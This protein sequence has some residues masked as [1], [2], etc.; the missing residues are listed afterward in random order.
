M[1]ENT[2]APVVD[3]SY[4]FSNP[5][6]GPAPEG[7]YMR[8]GKGTI[9]DTDITLDNRFLIVATNLGLYVY[10]VNSLKLTR[11]LPVEVE[12]YQ[13]EINP[14]GTSFVSTDF[15]GNLTNW[16][17]PTFELRETILIA[18]QG[19]KDIEFTSD[20][21]R[22]IIA[23]LDQ[24]IRNLDT[25]KGGIIKTIFFESV[26]P[27]SLD[28]H[29][30]DK[31]IAVLFGNSSFS[32]YDIES[33]IAVASI[34][35]PNNKNQDLPSDDVYYYNWFNDRIYYSV[36]GSLLYISTRSHRDV[37]RTI[38]YEKI[39]TFSKTMDFAESTDLIKVATIKEDSLIITELDTGHAKV[40]PPIYGGSSLNNGGTY[41]EIYF[42]HDSTRLIQVE[43]Y[44]I[45]LYDLEDDY[46]VHTL[47][48]YE[49]FEYIDYLNNTNQLLTRSMNNPFGLNP[50][51][52]WDENLET[53][54]NLED[55]I[56][57]KN[58]V[59]HGEEPQFFIQ[60]PDGNFIAGTLDEPYPE[61]SR[62][63]YLWN[64][65][66][67]EFIKRLPSISNSNKSMS[68]SWDNENIAIGMKDG[69]VQILSIRSGAFT[70][71]INTNQSWPIVQ[72]SPSGKDLITIGTD[73]SI[74]VWETEK[75][76]LIIEINRNAVIYCLDFSLDGKVMI[77]GD[78]KG[79]VL[80]WDTSTWEIVDQIE[81]SEKG[82]SYIKISHDQEKFALISDKTI[83]VWGFSRIEK[84]ME[85]QAAEPLD[86]LS[87][88]GDDRFLLSST[89]PER[90]SSLFGNTSTIIWQID[91]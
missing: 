24:T 25:N 59:G 27:I 7:A 8:I 43:T 78:S 48:G 39:F 58:D 76:S 71:T 2:T 74:K 83:Q 68:F 89:N 82:I 73:G 12:P 6:V 34:P 51:S 13:V 65:K 9:H 31:V 70:H 88:S 56:F 42:S 21:S 57:K 18:K 46:Q 53:V 17:L 28:V 81:A 72:Y 3:Y 55:P 50:P 5:H 85:I 84:I 90:S 36:D 61:G 44:Y 47:Q 77:T 91:I 62:F 16:D 75:Y 37:Y 40:Y 19:V 20:G 14:D 10:D 11:Y 41:I 1:P 69:S 60:S 52:I 23:C 4:M 33:G 45:K 67:G 49:I 35:S 54:I 63:L 29:P 30:S 80:I 32:I 22:L 38:N 79:N 66:T 15:N 87:F 26:V 64:S 86:R